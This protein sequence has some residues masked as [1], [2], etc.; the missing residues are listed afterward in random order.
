MLGLMSLPMLVDVATTISAR[1]EIFKLSSLRR[2]RPSDMGLRAR[3]EAPDV[4]Q[5]PGVIARLGQDEDARGTAGSRRV[6]VRAIL[7]NLGLYNSDYN[8]RVSASPKCRSNLGKKGE[9]RCH[10]CAK[11]A[12]SCSALLPCA[13]QAAARPLVWMRF[14]RVR[15]LCRF[16]RFRTPGSTAMMASR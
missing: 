2:S 10:R 16:F 8:L 6:R 3:F 1:A 14:C 7:Q 9:I 11:L 13:L 12:F 15:A 5:S 4:S